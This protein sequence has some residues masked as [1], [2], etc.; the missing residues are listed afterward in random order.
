VA[1]RA[2]SQVSTKIASSGEVVTQI[3]AGSNEQSRGVT[4]IGEAVARIEKVTQNNAANAQETA[5][6][7]A[8]MTTQMQTTRE[9]LA[10]CSRWSVSTSSVPQISPPALR[11]TAREIARSPGL[12]A[13]RSF[14]AG[15][16]SGALSR[17]STLRTMRRRSISWTVK[18]RLS[19]RR[20]PG[21][22]MRPNLYSR[23]PQGF[24]ASSGRT[25]P[26]TVS[27]TRIEGAFHSR[28]RCPVRA[29][30]RAHRTRRRWDDN[31]SSTSHVSSRQWSDLVHHQ[32][33]MDCPRGI[34]RASAEPAWFPAPPL[35][36]HQRLTW[37]GRAAARH[38]CRPVAPAT[39]SESL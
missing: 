17:F 21:L 30:A 18:R 36:P 8:E 24:E 28:C 9:H 37:K 33:Q 2:F 3:A 26:K 39:P 38:A 32:R 34:P 10:E 4:H 14:F 15:S 6:T 13:R 27:R 29:A 23:K 31:P 16:W 20:F 25:R 35:F 1:Q 11:L 12:F 19:Y 5:E 7:A 22:G